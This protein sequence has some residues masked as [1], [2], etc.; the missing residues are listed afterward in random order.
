MKSYLLIILSIYNAIG[1]SQEKPNINDAFGLRFIEERVIVLNKKNDKSVLNNPNLISIEVDSLNTY[2]SDIL[3]YRFKLGKNKVQLLDESI[4]ISINSS[5]C[6][7]Y[8]LALNINNYTSYRLK[9]FNG[10]D[11]LFLLRDINRLSS[12]KISSKKLL[13]SLSNLNIG[14]DFSGIYKALLSLDFE[15]ECLKT[16]SDGKEAHGKIHK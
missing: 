5:S 13:L 15:A 1:F 7:E 16:C 2:N 14:V 12:S 8:I 11:L 3:F 10:N 6:N 4:E 9:G